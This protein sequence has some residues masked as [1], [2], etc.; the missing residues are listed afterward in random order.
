MPHGYITNCHLSNDT[1]SEYD[2]SKFDVHAHL[3]PVPSHP[4]FANRPEL[5]MCH[6]CMYHAI[7]LNKRNYKHAQICRDLNG[8][9]RHSSQISYHH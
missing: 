7:I 1:V 3:P 6:V 9:M 8:L 4:L 5:S 2:T